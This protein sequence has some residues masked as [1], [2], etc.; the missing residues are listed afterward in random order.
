MD[1]SQKRVGPSRCY[2]CWSFPE[3][4]AARL[5]GDAGRPEP[6]RKPSWAGSCPQAGWAPSPLLKVLLP[7]R[8][9]LRVAWQGT[10]LNMAPQSQAPSD[11]QPP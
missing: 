10:P 6:T 2:G 8:A 1:L 9:G 5:R 3:P 4:T 11:L 7:R